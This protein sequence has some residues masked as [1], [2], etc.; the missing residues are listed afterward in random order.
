MFLISINDLPDD[1]YCK[2]CIFADD[3]TLY[4]SVGKYSGDFEKIQR[5]ADLEADIRFVTERGER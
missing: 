4:S 5:A 3:A 2:L 1:I